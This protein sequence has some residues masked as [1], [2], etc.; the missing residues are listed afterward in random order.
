MS[1]LNQPEEKAALLARVRRLKGQIEAIE[2][3]VEAERDCGKIL[4]LLASVR[5]AVSGLTAELFES[6]LTH[7]IRE[8]DDPEARRLGAEELSRALRVYLK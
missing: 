5:G 6:H 1:H 8:I 7:H 2:R 4:H 3:A